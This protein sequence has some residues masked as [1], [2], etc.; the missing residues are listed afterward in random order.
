ML[1]QKVHKR[2]NRIVGF[3]R[4]YCNSHTEV[5]LTQV[6]YECE[7]APAT[8]YQYIDMIT[9]LFPDIHYKQKRFWIEGIKD[10]KKDISTV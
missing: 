4:D 7:I 9:D 2:M 3:I 8:L 6:A 5:T 1:K 10:Q